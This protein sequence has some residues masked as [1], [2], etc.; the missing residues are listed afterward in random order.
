LISEE[1]F[2]QIKNTEVKKEEMIKKEIRKNQVIRFL[3]SELMKHEFVVN[4]AMN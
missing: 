3:Q 4:P 2:D 1:V